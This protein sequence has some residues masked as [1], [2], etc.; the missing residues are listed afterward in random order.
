MLVFPSKG[1]LA[2]I[3]TN[4]IPTEFVGVHVRPWILQDIRNSPER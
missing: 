3:D 1:S 2:R 4:E